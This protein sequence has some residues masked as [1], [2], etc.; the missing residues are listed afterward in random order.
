M[1][2]EK[3]TSQMGVGAVFVSTLAV[4]RL[5]EE[6]FHGPDEGQRKLL[7]ATIQPIVAFVVMCS[8]VIRMRFLSALGWQ[9]AN[10]CPPRWPLHPVLFFRPQRLSYD[11]PVSYMDRQVT[12]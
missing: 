8:I 11:V 6:N 10:S 9:L 5:G 3:Y 12:T 7:A 2:I 1:R 4:H